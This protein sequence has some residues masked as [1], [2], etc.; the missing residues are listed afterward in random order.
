MTVVKS[1]SMNIY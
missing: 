1:D